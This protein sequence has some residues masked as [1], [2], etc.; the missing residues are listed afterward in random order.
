ME[1]S[2]EVTGLKIMTTR[3]RDPTTCPLLLL[4]GHSNNRNKVIRTI[5]CVRTTIPLSS[6]L[7]QTTADHRVDS[8]LSVAKVSAL[9]GIDCALYISLVM[10]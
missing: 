5:S 8:V 6:R 9:V 3:H 2:I 4:T 10:F 7:R 1:C